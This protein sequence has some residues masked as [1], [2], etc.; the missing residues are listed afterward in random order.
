MGNPIW[1]SLPRYYPDMGGV[2]HVL[3]LYVW[4]A[5]IILPNCC[6]GDCHG[7]VV[8]DCWDRLQFVV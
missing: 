6:Q 4:F 2:I 7:F 5:W 3:H 1:V 8:A